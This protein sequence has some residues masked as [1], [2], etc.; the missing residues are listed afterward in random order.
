MEKNKSVD[1][2]VLKTVGAPPANFVQ[3][4]ADQATAAATVLGAKWKA[5]IQ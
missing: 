3:L 4:T 5:A 1:E 2:A